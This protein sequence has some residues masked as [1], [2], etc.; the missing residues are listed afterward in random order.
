MK[1][2]AIPGTGIN[3]S[4][5]RDRTANQTPATT[6]HQNLG[7]GHLEL[8]KPVEVMLVWHNVQIERLRF[9]ASILNAGLD[10]MTEMLIDEWRNT[11]R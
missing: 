3:Q 6:T 11:G 2:C 9:S 4:V 10:H 5:T 7:V 8:R 1:L